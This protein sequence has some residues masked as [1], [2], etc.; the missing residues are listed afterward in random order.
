[1]DPS[2]FTL[3]IGNT[4]ACE[5]AIRPQIYALNEQIT[6]LI[7]NE[8][9]ASGSKVS[10]GECAARILRLYQAGVVLGPAPGVGIT[11]V[12]SQASNHEQR[13][14][15][16]LKA[17]FLSK[18][19]K[20]AA[21]DQAFSTN[22]DVE[23]KALAAFRSVQTLEKRMRDLGIV[24]PAIRKMVEKA[25]NVHDCFNL[26]TIEVLN[27]TEKALQGVVGR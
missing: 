9:P 6:R 2:R 14:C 17:D 11:A 13:A 12:S 16:T 21:Q 20:C 7:A 23:D 4:M 27:N 25:N 19:C 1:M 8:P 3:N 15:L 5:A 26:N 10:V 22:P 18:A 24:N